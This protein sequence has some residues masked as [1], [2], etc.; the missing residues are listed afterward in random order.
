MWSIDLHDNRHLVGVHTVLF[1]HVS[2]SSAKDLRVASVAAQ[3]QQHSS[4]S[5][6]RQDLR[7]VPRTRRQPAATP[8]DQPQSGLLIVIVCDVIG[9]RF[10]CSFLR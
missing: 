5:V 1:H 3:R 9:V 8:N 7:A 10:F 4:L 6:R 2:R